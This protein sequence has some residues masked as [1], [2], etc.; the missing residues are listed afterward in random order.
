[1]TLDDSPDSHDSHSSFKHVCSLLDFST[2]NGLVISDTG[3]EEPYLKHILADTIN[4]LGIDAIFFFKPEQG[5]PSVP[6]IYF[7]LMERSTPETIAELHK[8]SWNIGQ[9]PLL[10]IILPNS[11][12]IFNN[13]ERPVY[14]NELAGLIAELRIFSKVQDE[15]ALMEYQRA[16]FVTGN[17]W[18]KNKEQFNLQK[19]VF[20][21][22]LKNLDHI[23]T[24]LIN[25]GL[26]S[27]I[28]HSLLVRCIF[29][30]Y[31]E[32][33]HDMQGNS[34]FPA[35]YFSQ[36]YEGAESFMDLL[37]SKDSMFKFFRELSSKFNGDI[38][39]PEL[40]E[41]KIVKQEHLD[42]ISR[43]LSG[44]EYLENGQRTLWE[45]YSFGVIPIELISSIYEQFLL[46]KTEDNAEETRGVHYTPY[47]LV[48]F[49]MDQVLPYSEI[50]QNVR[51]FDP[52]C[53]SGIFLVEGY[54]RLVSNWIT[55][56]GYRKPEAADLIRILNENIFGIDVDERAIRVA[57][58]SL[59]LTL[60]DYLE[61]KTIWDNL[62]FQQLIQRRLYKGDFFDE[63]LKLPNEKFDLVIGNPPW[64]SKLSS[65]AERYANF[66]SI[67][68][69][70]GDKQICQLFLWKSAD[71]CKSEGK[72]CMIVSSKALL[73]NKSK[74]SKFR[75]QFFSTYAIKGIFNF[76]ALRFSLFSHAVGPSAAI[77]LSPQRPPEDET[78]FYCSP[79]PSYTLQDNLSFVI[80]PQDLANITLAD[81]LDF[82][83]IWKVAM[84]GTPRDLDL[85]KKLS[86]HP[87]LQQIANRHRWEHGE[88]Y[89]VGKRET[90]FTMDL[91][92][93][94]EV[95]PEDMQPFYIDPKA[96]KICEKKHFWT[97]GK[98][99]LSIYKGPHLLIKQSPGRKT[100]GFVAAVMPEDAVFSQSIVGL[101]ADAKD[102]NQLIALCKI[103]NSEIPLYFSLMT[104]GRWLVER[105]ELSKEELMNLPIPEQLLTEER[106]VDLARLSKN[107]DL[108]LL[109]KEKVLDA[110]GLDESERALVHDTI[111][112]TIDYFNLKQNSESLKAPAE[113]QVRDYLETICHILNNGLATT[114]RRFYGTLFYSK[115]P[116]RLISLKLSETDM[117]TVTTEKND[118]I[119]DSVLQQLD[120]ELIKKKSGS[121]FV[122]KHFW[123]YAKD[124]VYIIKPNQ[125]R[126]WSNT[127]AILDS[128]K[129]YA[130]I[131]TAWRNP[132]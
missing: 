121:V 9:A 76:S 45:L 40:S 48:T 14:G 28:I 108:Q 8:L 66:H 11:V 80:E 49:L 70:I 109:E 115:G 90:F 87:T 79:K 22:L 4:K 55:S 47:H 126:Y 1:M 39:T 132:E 130:D 96:L 62:K 13:L 17:F 122:R 125:T 29:T 12:Q 97:W 124:S 53:G 127:S 95:T 93:K 123:R 74:S 107:E 41:E 89:I 118:K 51:I 94:P 5:G 16:E 114:Q 54:R 131:M 129:V 119:M 46:L 6:L 63:D 32:D 64:D 103:I 61:P 2:E 38:F 101:H 73:F 15:R 111:R 81:A 7:K 78:I 67:S 25:N 120:H 117:E 83:L 56:N 34:V 18:R 43:G 59:Y 58:L 36:F 23:R 86:K 99:K 91:Y 68:K 77:I 65:F 71:F 21:S 19:N 84:W 26:P 110:Y 112:Y 85:I 35:G 98:T 57:A 88:G 92:G 72:I 113:S 20:N 3:A 10:F 44:R 116:L 52:A 31:L 102:I 24:K 33:R 104:S 82:E 106:N 50:N 128:D 37:K 105:D 27:N 42:L 60:C 100:T 30:K 69:P 75:R